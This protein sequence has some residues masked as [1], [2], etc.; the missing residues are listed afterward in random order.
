MTK[1]H[2]WNLA[3][4]FPQDLCDEYGICGPNGVYRYR[5]QKAVR[6]HCLKGFSP[7]FRKYWDLQ[8]WSGGCTRIKPLNCR[9]RDGF[10]EVR[11]VKY[12]DMLKFWLNATMK[13]WSVQSYVL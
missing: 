11:G 2:K 13:P 1:K 12:P 10:V 4:T 8:D 9:G 6:C 3:Y 7:K 5:I